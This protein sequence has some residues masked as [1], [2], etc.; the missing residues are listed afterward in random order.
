[1]RAF[2]AHLVGQ[3][4]GDAA[5]EGLVEEHRQH[6]LAARVRKAALVEASQQGDESVGGDFVVE[7]CLEGLL[8][9]D[10]AHDGHAP[11]AARFERLRRRVRT[12]EVDEQVGGEVGRR[13]DHVVGQLAQLHRL[14]DGRVDVAVRVAPRAHTERGAVG[15]ALEEV[16]DVQPVAEREAATLDGV[17]QRHEHAQFHRARRVKRPVAVQAEGGA[18]F[19]V[20]ERHGHGLRPGVRAGGFDAV[21]ERFGHGGERP[22][23]FENLRVW[24]YVKAPKVAGCARV[25][26]K[27]AVIV[28]RRR[29][30]GTGRLIARRGRGSGAPAA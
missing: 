12:D 8:V 27:V 25:R 7:A 30:G 28:R 10:A 15:L 2:V 21:A 16:A 5:V 11:D 20:V 9:L 23:G 29:R 19:E 13:H 1:M 3:A 6:R 22:E 26:R 14:A 18:G 24:R 4:R 17:E